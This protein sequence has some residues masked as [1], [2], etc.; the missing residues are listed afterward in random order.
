MPVVPLVNNPG[1]QPVRSLTGP[2]GG[3]RPGHGIDGCPLAAAT[4]VC[5]LLGPRAV[6]PSRCGTVPG[7]GRTTITVVPTPR[8]L[9]TLIWPPCCSTI[10]LVLARPMPAPGTSPAVEAR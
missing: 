3:H 10:V 6:G 2:G 9:S 4:P 7:G 8:A 5:L 1:N